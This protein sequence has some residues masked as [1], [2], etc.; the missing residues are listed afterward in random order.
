MMGGQAG[1]LVA[2]AIGVVMLAGCVMAEKYE[3]EKARAMNFQRLLAQEE[4]RTGEMDSEL[5]RLKRDSSDLE[6]RNRELAAQVQAVREQLGRMQEEAAAMRDAA[7][8]KDQDVLGKARKAPAKGKRVDKMAPIGMD[9]GALAPVPMPDLAP[10]GGATPRYHEVR[11]G[12]TLMAIG[13]LY[14]V[15]VNTLK[16]LN[17]MKNNT[18]HVGQRLVVGRE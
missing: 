5:K 17:N 12:D 16:L 4:K 9:P 18:I 1:R 6:A 11:P 3:A 2:L 7:L 10:T 15:D 14:G 13:R 8:L